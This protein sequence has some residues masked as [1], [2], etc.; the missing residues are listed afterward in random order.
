MRVLASIAAVIFCFP[1][2]AMA[3]EP[4]NIGVL[5]S[6]T[7]ILAPL[8]VEQVNGMQMAI[9]EFGGAI[10]G[11]PINMIVEDDETKPNIGLQKARKLI[12]SDHVDVIAGVLAS[13]VALA[14][15]PFAEANKIPIVLSN[16]G[17]NALTDAS[18]S[19]WVFRVSFSDRQATEPL[20]PWVAK[21]GVKRVF[22]LTSDFVAS[23]EFSEGF[24]KG[25]VAAGGQIVGEAYTPFGATND[26][27]PYL[28]QAKATNPDAIF[29][30]YF[31]AE[32]ILF[33]KQYASF[34][35]QGKLDLVSSMGL[36]PQMLRQAQGD[37]A[38]DVTASLNYVPELDTPEN[39]AF[40]KKY[41]EKYGATAAEFAVMGYDSM[42]FT[43]EAIKS[44]GGKTDDHAAVAAAIG[45][46]SYVGPR[47]PMHIDPR[48][49][50]IIQNIY[51]T[52][53][54]KEGDR[55]VFKVLDTIPDVT[56][57]PDACHLKT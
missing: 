39:Q 5:M 20:G 26:F 42:R 40:Q 30:L 34:G 46:V 43:L 21:Q 56:D 1:L 19:P 48:T 17:A 28:A 14:I 2:P 22:I 8:V 54:V 18:C 12:F 11:R 23:R 7:G 32:A 50:N 41:K 49:N 45:K 51:I 15:T 53:T 16:A 24:S 31:G 25:F 38:A 37:S 29:G 57:P 27:G 4:I 33:T 52:K 13:P 36:T 3:S 10:A 44:L 47:G 9:D 35:L 55:V 6:S